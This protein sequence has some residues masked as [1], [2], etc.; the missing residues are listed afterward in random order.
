MN[1]DDLDD[2][3]QLRN[4]HSFLH[5]CHGAD[6]L[7]PHF[8]HHSSRACRQPSSH[9]HCLNTKRVSKPWNDN[10]DSGP[11]CSHNSPQMSSSRSSCAKSPIH[12][13]NLV[14]YLVDLRMHQRGPDSQD[15]P[16]LPTSGCQP[17]SHLDI[18]SFHYHHQVLCVTVAWS[19]EK[20]SR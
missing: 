19:Q 4:L 3:L 16:L 20:V 14:R 15:R 5:Q 10:W 12:H 9:V 18:R 7:P 11:L 1:K 2:E 17:S 13:P 6:A 8:S